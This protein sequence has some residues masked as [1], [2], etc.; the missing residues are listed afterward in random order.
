MI[1]PLRNFKGIDLYIYDGYINSV[2]P[3]VVVLNDN[4]IYND[5]P[6][7]EPA[8]FYLRYYLKNTL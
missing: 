8:N 7:S 3:F 6:E 4:V 5:K 1:F 2:E